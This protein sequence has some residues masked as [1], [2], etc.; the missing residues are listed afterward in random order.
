MMGADRVLRLAALLVVGVM[1]GLGGFTLV[2][3]KGYSYLVDDPEA[4]VNCHIM[5]DN[6][7]SWTVS[8]HRT[9]TCNGCHTPHELV[10]KYLTKAEH[11][12]AHSWAFT[13]GDPQVV[14]IKQR[15]L[16][17]VEH[18]CVQCHDA[19]TANL[20]MVDASAPDCVRCHATVGHAD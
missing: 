9:I 1:I 7:S 18:N 4:C 2:Y 5:R 12:V 19:M 8:S 3:A 11:G 17:V 10:P 20:R 6:M 16:D 15:S 13:F 14:R